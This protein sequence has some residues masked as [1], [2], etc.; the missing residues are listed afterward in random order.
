M[1][2]GPSDS[3]QFIFYLKKRDGRRKDNFQTQPF[4]KFSSPDFIIGITYIYWLR[5]QMLLNNKKE[6]NIK[7]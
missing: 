3:A 2:Q 7:M 1:A 5:L 4:L 6:G